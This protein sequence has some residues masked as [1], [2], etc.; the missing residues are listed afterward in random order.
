MFA[1]TASRVDRVLHRQ[2][3][4]APQKQWGLADGLGA[5][6]RVRIGRVLQSEEEKRKEKVRSQSEEEQR[7]EKTHLEQ[8]NVHLPGDVVG[9]GDLWEESWELWEEKRYLGQWRD[10]WMEGRMETLTL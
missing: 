4:R 5:R 3:D 8:S 2:E 1:V 6:H 10:G 9:G 7:K